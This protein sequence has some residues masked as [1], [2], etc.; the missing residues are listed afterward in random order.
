MDVYADDDASEYISD[1]NGGVRF[2]SG[3]PGATKNLKSSDREFHENDGGVRVSRNLRAL[4]QSAPSSRAHQGASSG[5]ADTHAD[6]DSSEY[7]A[8]DDHLL[9]SSSM[10]NIFEDSKSVD[11]EF[12]NDDPG[13]RVARN[14][15]TFQKNASPPGAR[16]DPA[17]GKADADS[18][19]YASDDH[20]LLYSSGMTG[21]LDSSRLVDWE[22]RNNDGGVRVSRNLR[23]FQN[24]AP[25]PG[26]DNSS[27][28]DVAGVHADTDSSE[29][30]SDDHGLLMSRGV[31]ADNPRPAGRN[32]PRNQRGCV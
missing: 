30:I 18:S 16:Q 2:N 27:P 24:S 7:N 6:A 17:P 19:E 23:P 14:L 22:F 31:T 28:S 4:Q 26:A 8:D 12:R 5:N 25:R 29:Y 11:W 9:S 10:T 1:E 15:R 3:V 32:H 20:D 13:T 21:L